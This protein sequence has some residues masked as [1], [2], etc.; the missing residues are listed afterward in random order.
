MQSALSDLPVNIIQVTS[1]EAKAL[2]CHTKTQLNAHHSPDLFHGL[3]EI[4]KGMF[5]PLS[6]QIKRANKKHDEAVQEGQRLVKERQDGENQPQYRSEKPPNFEKLIHLSDWRDATTEVDLEKA[7]ARKERAK[8]ILGEIGN[9]YHPF[10]LTTGESRQAEDVEQLLE[11][12]FSDLDVIAQE[13]SLSERA[14]QHIEKAHRLLPSMLE[15]IAFFWSIVLMELKKL[16]LSPH[17]EQA[18]LQNLVPAYYLQIVS[19]KTPAQKRRTILSVSEKLLAPLRELDGPFAGLEKEQVRHLEMVA[20]ECAEFFQRSSSCV[21]G[22]NG[23]LSLRHHNQHN[24]SHRK[25]QAL[26]VVH[27]FGVERPDGT[28]AAERFFGHK[29]K[30]LFEHLLD[31]ID[32]PARPAKRR[33]RPVSQPWLIAA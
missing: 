29:P 26:T 1:D 5:L 21:E 32:L 19:G 16:E 6:S 4:G 31:R 17:I 30:D 11:K 20:R 33:S 25:L 2:I 22:R 15:T 13:A 14:I 3:H 9:A 7:I 12:S 24:I 10:D 23:H 18:M 27:N 28:T 8:A